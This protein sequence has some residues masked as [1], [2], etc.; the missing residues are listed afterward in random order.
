MDAC[1]ENTPSTTSFH[2]SMRAPK[3]VL[4]RA[5][6]RKRPD[7]VECSQLHLNL[8]F[9]RTHMEEHKGKIVKQ[10]WQNR[11]LCVKLHA[12]TFMYLK[13]PF[14]VICFVCVCVCVCVCV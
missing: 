11:A 9:L 12:G 10:P 2:M 1:N 13:N 14:S 3:N 4:P 5:Y 6:S 8:T 7:N